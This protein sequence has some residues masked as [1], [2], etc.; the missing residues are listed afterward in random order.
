MTNLLITL[1]FFCYLSYVMT[2][3]FEF[4]ADNAAVIIAHVIVPVV[5]RLVCKDL[6]IAVPRIVITDYH[7]AQE[8]G[9]TLGYYSIP[10]ESIYIHGAA[11]MDVYGAKKYVYYLVQTLAHELRHA[12]QIVEF[13]LEDM[14]HEYAG[15]PYECNFYEIEARA[16]ASSYLDK[17]PVLRKL[18]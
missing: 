16:Y 10:R 3:A 12:S 15:T 17:L 7:S 13:G 11:I 2:R 18:G 6:G 9:I 1:I 8:D 4:I 5:A 14:L